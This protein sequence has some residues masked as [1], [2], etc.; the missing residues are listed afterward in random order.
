MLKLLEKFLHDKSERVRALSR[1]A[2]F[3]LFR[4]STKFDE[5]ARKKLSTSA[6][7]VAE[8]AGLCAVL[9]HVHVAA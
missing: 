9:I 2:V 6:F 5:I 3:N 4:C 7:K 1:Q 8:I